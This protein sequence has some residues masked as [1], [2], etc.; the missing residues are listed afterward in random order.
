PWAA[1]ELKSQHKHLG[2]RLWDPEPDPD[3]PTECVAIGD[4]GYISNGRFVR[5][6]NIRRRRDDPSHQQHGVPEG[7]RP[8][9]PS[10]FNIFQKSRLNRGD[11]CS[12]SVRTANAPNGRVYQ[13]KGREKTGAVLHLPDHAI[14]HDYHGAYVK[15]IKKYLED[16]VQRFFEF[17]RDRRE[18]FPDVKEIIL[19]TGYTVATSWAAA[20]FLDKKIDARLEFQSVPNDKMNMQWHVEDHNRERVW[21]D[22]S[23]PTQGDPL[24]NQCIY[25]RGFQARHKH[26]KDNKFEI[27][28]FGAPPARRS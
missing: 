22:T 19:V 7:Y 3:S 25:I 23:N 28:A 13:S 17:A 11:Y 24:Y 27:N 14:N 16:N 18:Q 26:A 5:L 12:R 10:P 9:P 21:C 4:V 8:I 15:Q 6:F 2:W 20:V 1:A